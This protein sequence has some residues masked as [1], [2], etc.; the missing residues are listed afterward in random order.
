MKFD[1]MENDEIGKLM[2]IKKSLQKDV[3]DL[4]ANH[5]QWVTYAAIEAISQATIKDK[6]EETRLGQ[7]YE[8]NT[9]CAVNEI[10]KSTHGYINL[11]KEPLG[12][13]K[14]VD[15]MKFA[16]GWKIDDMASYPIT[17][18]IVHVS[19]VQESVKLHHMVRWQYREEQNEESM[20][21]WAAVQYVTRESKGVVDS[22]SDVKISLEIPEQLDRY[23][24]CSEIWLLIDYCTANNDLPLFFDTSNQLFRHWIVRQKVLEKFNLQKEYP[25]EENSS[26]SFTVKLA[27][28][29]KCEIAKIV[30]SIGFDHNALKVNEKVSVNFS[31]MGQ[32]LATDYNFPDE[33]L[34]TGKYD[35]W[36]A[37]NYIENIS[38]MI[39]HESANESVENV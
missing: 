33:V 14:S 20:H 38:K 21:C 5:K 3:A 24:A 22:I 27:D 34:K 31:E 4:K 26:E 10:A 9:M 17:S 39:N 25:M 16:N 7:K 23:Y 32:K 36:S 30:W 12:S 28:K 37:E 15:L 1:F 35:A 18:E 11:S 29:K 8:Q 19:T 6:D 2:E 13:T